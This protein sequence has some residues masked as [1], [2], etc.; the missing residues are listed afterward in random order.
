MDTA[1]K[2]EGKSGTKQFNA[3]KPLIYSF[4]NLTLQGFFYHFLLVALLI[5]LLLVQKTL[6]APIP[7][8]QK[9]ESIP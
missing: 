2:E 6:L 5:F 3:R 7:R 1:I 9:A 4:V 8:K